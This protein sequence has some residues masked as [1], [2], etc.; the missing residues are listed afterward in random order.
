MR[1]IATFIAAVA[2]AGPAAA[3]PPEPIGKSALGLS[4][5]TPATKLSL[6]GDLVLLS[7]APLLASPT[8]SIIATGTADP[9]GKFRVEGTDLMSAMQKRTLKISL[10]EAG[11][12]SAINGGSSDRTGAVITNIV[13]TVG[14]VAGIVAAAAPAS[15]GT[16]P[17]IPC[18]DV[19]MKA[20]VLAGNLTDEIAKQRGQLAGAT[21]DDTRKIG[22]QI[23]VLAAQLA[24]VRTN[25]LTVN[26]SKDLAVNAPDS[27]A[28]IQWTVEGL[29]KWF[30]TAPGEAPFTTG[31]TNNCEAK[32][33]YF[34]LAYAIK[35][36][37]LAKTAAKSPC[38]STSTLGKD[39]AKACRTSIVLVE[40][41]V[42][43]VEVKAKTGDLLGLKPGDLVGK[44]RTPISQWG[45][46]TYFPLTVKFAQSRSLGLAFDQFGRPQ[47]FDWNSEATAENATGAL[48]N[49]L[50]AGA[51]TQ[52]ALNGKSQVQVWQEEITELE[53]QMKLT[54]L[55]ACRTAIE[56]G[57]TTCGD[58]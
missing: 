35:G 23:D 12:I 55:R 26:L 25:H 41:V 57:G 46:A 18:N 32:L 30:A 2:V 6:K 9:K 42:G 45:E 29:G 3:A 50:E 20:L 7:C 34:E 51:T 14:I 8:F 36:T 48:V 44:A 54:K 47:S 4:N 37:P 52:K 40:P 16:P 24:S 10:T 19:T 43:V 33:D 56:A 27:P 5:S 39:Q 31:G 28:E 13:K 49:I 21:P 11:T 58:Q 22:R 17:S 1:W 15:P 53:T 38:L